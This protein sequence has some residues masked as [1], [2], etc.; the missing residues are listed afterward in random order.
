MV[1]VG[2]DDTKATTL[3]VLDEA[4]RDAG[5]TKE[6]DDLDKDKGESRLSI[7]ETWHPL[8]I[9]MFLRAANDHD[10]YASE[11][12]KGVFDRSMEDVRATLAMVLE[13]PRELDDEALS[14][15]RRVATT[16]SK[17]NFEQFKLRLQN[18]RKRQCRSESGY[19]LRNAFVSSLLSA[20]R[21]GRVTL[22]EIENEFLRWKEDSEFDMK[23][24]ENATSEDIY[25]LIR[26]SLSWS[27]Q[28][29]V[30]AY[31]KTVRLLWARVSRI[32]CVAK[33]VNKYN[34]TVNLEA[35]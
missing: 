28:E 17:R 26:R 6:T 2:D 13:N 3:A 31:R 19:L 23:D 25:S 30:P 21:I 11:D 34:M 33:L 32:R 29:T 1:A 5:L 10:L 27:T 16:A 35:G 7:G 22:S 14:L 8:E 24:I 12:P 9:C 15:V 20:I 4:A 18:L